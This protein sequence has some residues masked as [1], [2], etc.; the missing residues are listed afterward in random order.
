L[1]E[2][3]VAKEREACAKLCEDIYSWPG[4]YRAGPLDFSTL[5]TAGA[6][7]RARGKP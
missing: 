5:K 2:M 3:A 7:I 1:V 6:A 4:A